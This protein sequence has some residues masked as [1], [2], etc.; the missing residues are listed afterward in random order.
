[1]KNTMKFEDGKPPS[2]AQHLVEKEMQTVRCVLG[3][4]RETETLC[5]LEFNLILL[6]PL[7]ELTSHGFVPLC[8]Y[9]QTKFL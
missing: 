5:C 6:H 9:R 2:G 7:L 3:C 1:M 4:R 8:A